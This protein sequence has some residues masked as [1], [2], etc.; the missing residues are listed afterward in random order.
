MARASAKRG[1]FG[2]EGFLGRHDRVFLYVPNL[3][4]A[5]APRRVTEGGFN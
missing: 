3:I 5:R 1:L 2:R 4:G